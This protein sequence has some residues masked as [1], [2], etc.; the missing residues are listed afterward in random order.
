MIDKRTNEHIFVN[1]IQFFIKIIAR[2][3]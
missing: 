3:L 2:S 1:Y